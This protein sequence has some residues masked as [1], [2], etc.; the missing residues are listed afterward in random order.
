MTA[1]QKHKPEMCWTH[2]VPSENLKELSTVNSVE[3][4]V[5]KYNPILSI[6]KDT[7]TGIPHLPKVHHMLLHFYKGPTSI[8]VSPSQEK[9]K[10]DSHFSGRRQ[11]AKTAFS[12]CFAKSWYRGSLH[13][14][15]KGWH[16]QAPSLEL[17]EGSQH[18]SISTLSRHSFEL[19]L[20]A[21]VL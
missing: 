18:L 13:P 7:R 8:P 10:K 14:K 17:G 20:W 19:C 11:K 3:F 1:K 16:H 21:S 12:V 5:T 9:S 4:W 6:G 15:Q 2:W